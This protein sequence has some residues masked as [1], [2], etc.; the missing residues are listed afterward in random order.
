MS[1]LYIQTI[2]FRNLKNTQLDFNGSGKTSILESIY[3]LGMGKSFR[4][5]LV[6]R[7]VSYDEEVFSVFGKVEKNSQIIPVGIERSLKNGRKIRID[8][9]DVHSNVE[10]TKLLPIQLLDQNSYNLFDH[11]PKLRRQFIDWGVFHVEQLFLPIW[12]KFERVIEQR[13]AAIRGGSKTDQIQAWDNKFVELAKELNIEID[14]TYRPGWDFD[15]DLGEILSKNIEAD[16]KLG[17][18]SFGPQRA[19][20]TFKINSVPI[21]DVFSRGQKKLFVYALQIAQGVLFNNIT[22]KNC[23]YLIDDIAAE[24][25]NHKKKLL[26]ETLIQLR[27][28]LFVTGLDKEDMFSL[29]ENSDKKLFHVEHGVV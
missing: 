5:H 19:D 8:G 17:Y 9:E 28:Q 27:A 21:Q 26:S 10:L 18:T 16:L 13:N 2:N 11:G 15:I 3:Y 12:R 23:I 29:F 20:L 1:I 25:D 14:I 22:D 6:R 24:L 4:S 7:I